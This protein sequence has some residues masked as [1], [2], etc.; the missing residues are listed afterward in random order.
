LLLRASNALIDFALPGTLQAPG[1]ARDFG[2][3]PR[4]FGF[5]IREYLIAINPDGISMS[6]LAK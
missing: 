5:R 2:T 3:A 6:L 4:T 1:F